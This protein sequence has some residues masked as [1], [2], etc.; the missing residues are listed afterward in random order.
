[1]TYDPALM[2]GMSNLSVNNSWSPNLAPLVIGA[3]GQPSFGQALGTDQYG[4]ST[5]PTFSP[6]SDPF[7]PF[8][9][10]S[11]SSSSRLDRRTKEGEV[12]D[13][14][15]SSLSCRV[16]LALP[17]SFLQATSD[18]PAVE[19][20]TRATVAVEALLSNTSRLLSNLNRGK[21]GRT[22]S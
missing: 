21:E 6:T 11:S 20:V 1:M 10:S 2:M 3:G 8:A 17:P 5:P 15:S 14:V 4:H 7:N 9:V 13:I 22:I 12:A 16:L 18:D 19:E